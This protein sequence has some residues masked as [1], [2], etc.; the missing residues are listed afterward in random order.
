MMKNCL[1][2]GIHFR[3]LL[4]P[5]LQE[6]QRKNGY[7]SEEALKKISKDAKIPISRLYGIATFYAM[8]HTKKQGKYVIEVCISP[9]CCV[10]GSNDIINVLE[11]ELKISIGETT[12]NK[13]FSL[14]SSSCIGCCDEAPAIL[15]NGKPYKRLNEKKI[16]SILKKLR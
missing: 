8:L 15:I 9:S 16:K 12:K 14:Y 2:E 13:L 7:I 10:N 11:H 6:E 5:I 4:L 1:D 3:T